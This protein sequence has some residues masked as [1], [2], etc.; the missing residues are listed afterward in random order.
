MLKSLYYFIHTLLGY[1]ITLKEKTIKVIS[2]PFLRWAGGKRRLV[3]RL[4]DFLPKET[5]G[6]YWEPFLGSGA[7]FFALAPQKAVLSDVNE[8]LIRCYEAVKENPEGVSDR[9]RKYASRASEN[10]YYKARAKYN[11]GMGRKAQAARF[12]FLNRTSFN[13]IYRVNTNGTYNVPYGHKEPPPL[14]TRKEL[15]RASELLKNATLHKKGY[16]KV[17]SFKKLKAKDFVYLDPPYLPYK[18]GTANFTHYTDSRFDLEDHKKLAK[19]AKQ[20]SKK[21]CFVMISSSD[22]PAIRELY[23]WG[24]HIYKLPVTRFI[25]ANGSR[26]EVS[27]LIITNYRARNREK[28]GATSKK[29][30]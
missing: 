7:L 6:T 23:G 19:M 1:K 14:P 9:L 16:T 5:Y 12:I 10:Y 8:E 18:E 4:I 26:S 17:L 24:W 25:A 20:I 29:S 2:P 22:D 3:R 21:G 13:G 15:I 27:E 30:N 11:N 28:L